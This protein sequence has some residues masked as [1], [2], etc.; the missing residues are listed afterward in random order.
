VEVAKSIGVQTIFI[1]KYKPTTVSEEDLVD[2]TDGLN[3]FHQRT[4]A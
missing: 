2:I 1:S 3:P 4:E